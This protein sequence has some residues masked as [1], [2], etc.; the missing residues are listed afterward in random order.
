MPKK[1]FILSNQ[2]LSS[3]IIFSKLLKSELISEKKIDI[4]GIAFTTTIYKK[5]GKLSGS[6]KL[7]KRMDKRYWLF[8]VISNLIFEILSK[9]P[10]MNISLKRLAN[11]LNIPI[12][13]SSNFNS[14]E[15]RNILLQSD[16]DI[17]IIRVN[18]ILSKDVL[19]IPK[20]GVYCVHSSILPSYRGIAGEFHA[21]RHNEP[22]IGSSIFKVIE[23]VD[24][25]PVVAIKS[26]KVDENCLLD[27][28]IRNNL[29][30]GELLI[31]FLS[32]IVYGKEIMKIDTKVKNSYYSWPK[33]DEV[34]QFKSLGFRFFCVKAIIKLFLL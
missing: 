10:F 16:V 23:A 11:K 20:D 25:G 4:V 5:G 33:Q 21:L 26:F 15:F 31:S 29:S 6:F 14:M 30:A 1:V 22:V 17:I 12:Y 2:D 9:L 7:L 13:Y 24:K 3:N 27:I 18:Q 32:D 8:L 19:S 34:D 28:I